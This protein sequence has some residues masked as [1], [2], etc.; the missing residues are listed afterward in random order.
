MLQEVAENILLGLAR[1]MRTR[2]RH[3]P[4]TRV[5]NSQ[6]LLPRPAPLDNTLTSEIIAITVVHDELLTMRIT[7]PDEASVGFLHAVL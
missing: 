7:T 1:Y 2:R 5:W 4:F 6:F 3:C